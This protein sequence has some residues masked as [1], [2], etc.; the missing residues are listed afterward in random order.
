MKAKRV[1]MTDDA[2]LDVD[3]PTW[4][5]AETAGVEMAATPLALT[6]EASPFLAIS[7]DHGAIKKLEVSALHNGKLIAVRLK[8]KSDKHD[9]IADLDSFLD[10]AAVIFPVARGASAVTMGAKNKPTNAWYWRAGR[11]KPFEVIAR[12]FK[13][14]QRIKDE[15]A[16]DLT[17][18]SVHRNGDSDAN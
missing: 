18:S 2:L 10:G 16:S 9:K 14:V 17:A 5:E 1:Q 12:G 8:W 15:S 11:S 13:S 6:A 7:D 4:K 3:S